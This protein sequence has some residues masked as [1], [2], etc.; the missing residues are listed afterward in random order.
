MAGFE[1]IPPLIQQLFSALSHYCEIHY[2]Q[3]V[4]N[5]NPIQRLALPN[6]QQE[7]TTMA[8]WAKQQWQNRPD[9]Q[10]ACVIP[11]LKQLRNRV[12]AIFTDV[13]L[14]DPFPTERDV[15][16]LPFNI[17]MG[18]PLSEYPLIATVFLILHLLQDEL[19]WVKL[20]ALL[21][22]PFILGAEQEL[23][24][25]ATVDAKGREFAPR[26]TQLTLFLQFL[27]AQNLCPLLS[28]ALKKL[29]SQ[30]QELSPLQSL[31][32][33]SH[34]F[35][36]Q[37]EI[38]G[39]PGQRNLTS[40]EYQQLQRW[41][42]LVTEFKN[43][44][45]V[46]EQLISFNE[47]LNTLQRLAQASLFQPK[48][49]AK[50]IQILGSLETIGHSFEQMW[51][52]GM[53]EHNW[54]QAPKPNVFIPYTLQCQFN[55]P[56]ATANRELNFSQKI[57]QSLLHSAKQ[58]YFSY[59]ETENDLPVNPSPLILAIAE[60]SL[61]NIPLKEPRQLADME[62]LP[63]AQGPAVT[64]RDF[65]RGGATLLKN[66][67]A[68]AF[69]AF[70]LHRLGATSLTPI[71]SGFSPIERGVI[72]HRLLEKIWQR[73]GDHT[74]L[75]SYDPD[76]LNQL[77]AEIIV[78][79]LQEKS[80]KSPMPFKQQFRLLEQQR[81]QQLLNEWLALEK[82]REPFTVTAQEQSLALEIAGLKL[83][84]RIDRE[85][86]LANGMRLIIDY[87]TGQPAIKDWF[88]ERPN[89]PQLLLYAFIRE[90]PIEALAFA[91]IRAE[92][93]AFIGLSEQDCSIAGIKPI[94]EQRIDTTLSNWQLFQTQ[95]YQALQQLAKNFMAGHASLNPKNPHE[96]CQHC[97]LHSLCR[98][99]D[100][101]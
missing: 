4:T 54:P 33:W 83:N 17:S 60:Q 3:P 92:A 40:S 70:A 37:L 78:A 20:S 82:T 8:T 101:H 73:L 34:Y 75:C 97:D 23:L 85:D 1:E 71:I 89:D 38:L 7:L 86:Q 45:S 59:A 14:P 96:T 80:Q 63:D 10:I 35:T 12:E 31:A 44:S 56:H 77:I 42:H 66:Q 61:P 48:C 69:R 98:K 2:Y 74:T 13:F 88:G 19:Q 95:Q 29:H 91:Q 22:S 6:Q 26:L 57:L 41:Q 72:M 55:L 18:K 76:Q 65:I 16:N 62:Y 100:E 5:A 68:C 87:K 94:A 24:S 15:A 43:L 11:E 50:P 25:R 81:L 46:D 90:H 64:D 93:M 28:A 47:A 49:A 30:H 52:M 51:I 58:I 21:R 79:T 84:L 36:R 39:W 32:S 9:T 27:T 99:Y 67:A 53:S